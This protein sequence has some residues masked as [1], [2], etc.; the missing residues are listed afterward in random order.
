MPRLIDVM[1]L[2]RDRVIGAWEIDGVVVDPGPE[3][4]LATLL[5]ELSQEPRALL[6][7]HI[8]L[9]HAGAAGAL[10]RRFS[11]LRVYVHE[12]GAQHLADPSRLVA[13]ARTV[14]GEAMERLWG[15]VLPVPPER[16]IP[17]RG[18]ET[19][20]G[21]R[22]IHAPGHAR[23][24]VCYL[25][26]ESGHAYVGDV[27]GARIPPAE[28]VVMPTPPP[29][30]DVEAWLRSLDAVADLGAERLWMTHFGEVS[31]PP[32][33][34]DEARQRLRDVAERSRRL[35]REP[36]LAALDHEIGASGDAQTAARYRQALPPDLLWMGL[37][38]Y[39]RRRMRRDEA[40]AR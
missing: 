18:G 10:A 26:L 37:E 22:V 31:D 13:S 6:L 12:L 33:H 21:C 17:L 14:F 23:H 24:H 28:L 3:S 20:E 9:D 1:H 4:C 32:A 40:G 36:F 7:T 34:I 11:G 38:H 16:I 15:E 2:G 39:W 19:V 27:A 25:H 5:G 29:D 8:H 35:E 30:I